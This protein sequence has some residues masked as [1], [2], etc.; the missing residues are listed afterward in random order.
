MYAHLQ[1]VIF[2]EEVVIKISHSPCGLVWNLDY[3]FFSEDYKLLVS[4]HY[5]GRIILVRL[6]IESP[7]RCWTPTRS[8]SKVLCEENKAK[9]KADRKND[10][11]IAQQCSM[12]VQV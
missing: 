6:I 8:R 9:E 12:E 11:K 5:F 3:N 4:V 10:E 1:L 2:L 7:S